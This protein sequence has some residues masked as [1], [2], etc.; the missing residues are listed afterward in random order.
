MLP[1][2][3]TPPLIVYVWIAGRGFERWR[4]LTPSRSKYL[5]SNTGRS[6]KN[7]EK[8]WQGKTQQNT[9]HNWE[10]KRKVTGLENEVARKLP[11]RYFSENGPNKTNNYQANAE[12]YDGLLHS[13]SFLEDWINKTFLL[14]NQ[15]PRCPETPKQEFDCLFLEGDCFAQSEPTILLLPISTYSLTKL[16]KN[17][18]LW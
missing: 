4:L 7:I 11:K 10:E 9:C 13:L 6:P 15:N 5:S 1:S 8:H 2:E 12:N 3:R 17:D 16:G 14:L 18:T